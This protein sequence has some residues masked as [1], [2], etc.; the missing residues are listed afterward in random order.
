MEFCSEYVEFEDLR[1]TTWEKSSE[2]EALSQ[3]CVW[4]QSPGE[5]TLDSWAVGE[6]LPGNSPSLYRLWPGS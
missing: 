5:S 1:D 2:Q 4:T 3:G 6:G